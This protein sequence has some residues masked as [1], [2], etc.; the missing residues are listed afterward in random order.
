MSAVAL[1]GVASCSTTV[2]TAP[3][4]PAYDSDVRPILMAPCAR[5]HGAGD[6]LNAPTEP[7]G[8]DAAVLP[9]IA[10]NVGG[11][12]YYF[13]RYS[14]DGTKAGA[15]TARA[16]IPGAIAAN[17][18]PPMRMPPAPAPR[19]SDWEVDVLT[20]WSKGSALCSTDPSPDSTICPNGP[21]P[22]P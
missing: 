14:S 21:G 2:G 6:A 3:S 10:A 7:T 4:Q 1:F 20:T 13:D 12:V 17:T 18:K 19:L 16:L 9:S 22:G 8:P 5:C 15:Y 11:I